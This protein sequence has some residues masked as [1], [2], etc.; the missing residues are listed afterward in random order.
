[1]SLNATQQSYLDQVRVGA[2]SDLTVCADLGKVEV[3]AYRNKNFRELL[4]A[5][6]STNSISRNDWITIFATGLVENSGWI[7]D[8]VLDTG[9]YA[10]IG[11]LHEVYGRGDLGIRIV[12]D[13]AERATKLPNNSMSFTRRTI[14]ESFNGIR[15][16]SEQQLFTVKRFFESLKYHTKE[17]VLLLLHIQE[18]TK[19]LDNAK[20]FD[21]FFATHIRDAVIEQSDQTDSSIRSLV[22]STLIASDE[23]TAAECLAITM[24]KDAG[25]K[26]ST[27]LL[28]RIDTSMDE[29][30]GVDFDI[31]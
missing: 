28:S 29:L 1:M 13:L 8:D 9:A 24:L 23:V 10:E 5:I 12:M 31:R 25:F 26:L 15:P 18:E 21:R 3:S 2:L 7:E 27:L 11:H 17:D 22:Y 16:M 30:M 6:D 14:R 19:G 20:G 4:F